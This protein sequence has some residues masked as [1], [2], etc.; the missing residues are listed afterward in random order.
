MI[1]TNRERCL[2]CSSSIQFHLISLHFRS[3]V[4]CRHAQTPKLHQTHYRSF[5]WPNCS[6]RDQPGEPRRTICSK[7]QPKFAG[8]FPAL[9][10]I[11]LYI[12]D[13]PTSSLPRISAC[14]AHSFI[15]IKAS[16]L[17]Y[18][19]KAGPSSANSRHPVIRVCLDLQC[20]VRN[21]NPQFVVGLPQG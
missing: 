15:Q 5:Q 7:V 13:L 3:A 16:I 4:P 14:S 10:F 17:P 2:T 11:S 1:K 18:F 19:R 21:S 9:Q 8:H 12:S 6:C 20:Q